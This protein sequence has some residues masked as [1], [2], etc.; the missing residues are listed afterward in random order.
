LLEKA[1][2]S[3]SVDALQAENSYKQAL[4]FATRTFGRVTV[5]EKSLNPWPLLQPAIRRVEGN[6]NHFAKLHWQT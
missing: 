6:G 1:S 2:Q 3:T 4:E 5:E